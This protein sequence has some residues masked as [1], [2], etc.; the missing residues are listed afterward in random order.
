MYLPN[1]YFNQQGKQQLQNQL[2]ILPAVWQM[3]KRN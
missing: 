1:G 2:K 3:L